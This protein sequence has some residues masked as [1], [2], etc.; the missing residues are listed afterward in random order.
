MHSAS[1]VAAISEMHDCKVILS[2][3]LPAFEITCDGFI[4]YTEDISVHPVDS[5][6][7]LRNFGRKKGHWEK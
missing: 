4:P 1:I 2:P 5:T 7:F 6:D 3:E